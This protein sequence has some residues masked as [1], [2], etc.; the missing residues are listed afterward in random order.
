[1]DLFDFS[2]GGTPWPSIDDVVM[3]GRSASTMRIEGRVAVFRGQVSLDGGGFAS[4]RSLPERRDLS[5]FLGVTLR[6]RG[7]G[8]RYGLRL[9]NDPAFDGVNYQAQITTRPGHWDEVRL[10][11]E[12]LRP[13]LRGRAMPGV[14]PLDRS[15]VW[16]FGLIIAER[17]AGPFRLEIECIRAYAGP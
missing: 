12:A 13:L 9:R 4:V 15:S 2:A 3:G 8:K 7:D 10:A 5:A 1:M 6:L 17:Q 14:P 16:T 11:F